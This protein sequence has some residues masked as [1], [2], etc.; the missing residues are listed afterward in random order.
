MNVKTIFATYK[1]ENNKSKRVLEKL[2]F[3]YYNEMK[4]ENY[5]G[6]IFEEIAM[7]LEI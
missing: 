7:K 6:E 2:G 3:K 1:T 4:N 5:L